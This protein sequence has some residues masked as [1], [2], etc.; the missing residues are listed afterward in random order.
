MPRKAKELL[1]TGDSMDADEAYRLGMVSKVF[2]RRRTGGQDAGIRR[3]AS[4][5]GRRWRR[6]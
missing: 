4:P 2:P 6:C 5:S 1:L 3:D